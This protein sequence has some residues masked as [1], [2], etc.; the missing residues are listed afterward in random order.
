MI[1]LSLFLLIFN[2]VKCVVDCY[3]WLSSFQMATTV[4]ER[5]ICVVDVIPC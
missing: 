2:E 4:Y 3:K 1:F 5:K